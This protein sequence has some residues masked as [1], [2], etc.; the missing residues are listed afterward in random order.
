VSGNALN[1]NENAEEASGGFRGGGAE[2]A[3]PSPLSDGLTPK[4]TILLICDSGTVL[5]RHRRHFYFFKHVKH[6]TQNIQNDCHHWL[7]D[8]FRVQQIRFRPGLCPDPA[9][10]AYNAP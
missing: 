7:C 5:W 2:P 6:G 8:S 3:P 9:E 10:G 4:L 1:D